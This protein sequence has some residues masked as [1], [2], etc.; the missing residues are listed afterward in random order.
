MHP[1]SSLLRYYIALVED[2]LPEVEKWS[3]SLGVNTRFSNGNHERFAKLLFASVIQFA[4]MLYQDCVVM[5]AVLLPCD[6]SI[7]VCAGV[8]AG[9]FL[10]TVFWVRDPFFMC[11]M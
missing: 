5:I 3:L 10:V 9:L 11:Q 2:D 7:D 1:F 8:R 6:S 4:F